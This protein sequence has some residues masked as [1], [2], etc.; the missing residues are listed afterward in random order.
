MT[1]DQASIESMEKEVMALKKKIHEARRAL[2]PEPV[3]DHTLWRPDGHA[4]S[5]HE[6]FNGKRDLIVVH[7]MGRSCVYCTV[8][9]DGFVGFTGHIADRAGF[10]LTSPDEPDVL[11]EFAESRGWTFPCASHAG[12]TFAKDLGFQPKPGEN[13]PGA[14]GL[15]LRDDGSIV[16]IAK[17]MFGP[18]DDFCAIW[19]LLELLEGGAGKWQPKLRYGEPL[20]QIGKS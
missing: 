14:S 3:K 11:R 1:T 17:S 4:V 15:R 12:T 5:L 7:N 2:P 6:L 10:V 19:P 8:W 18:G 16:R 9:A 20:V 13:W